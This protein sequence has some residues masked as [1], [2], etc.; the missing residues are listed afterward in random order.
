MPSRDNAEGVRWAKRASTRVEAATPTTRPSPSNTIG[1]SVLMQAR[2][3]WG[4]RTST[5]LDVATEHDLHQPWERLRMLASARRDVRARGERGVEGG[6][7]SSP[8]DAPTPSN[9]YIRSGC[10]NHVYLGRWRREPRCRRAPRGR[11]HRISRTPRSRARSCSRAP[12]GPGRHGVLDEVAVF[13]RAG[14]HLRG[15]YTCTLPR[16]SRVLAGIATTRSRRLAPSRLALEKRHL[17]FAG[18]SRTGSGSGR[19]RHPPT[20]SPALLAAAD[21]CASMPRSVRAR[22]ARRCG[23][24]P[25]RDRRR[26]GAPRG[27]DVFEGSR[28]TTAAHEVASTARPGVRAP[29]PRRRPGETPQSHGRRAGVI[30]LLAEQR[31][32]E[33]PGLVVPGA[34]ST[35]KSRDLRIS[36][37]RRAASGRR[38]LPL[39]ILKDI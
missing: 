5:E 6:G 8:S 17:W 36:T 3:K 23:A 16:G 26:K 12:R 24:C 1:T 27:A 13:R 39:G 35:I 4:A 29:R 28:R 32:A 33:S 22:G 18:S 11:A 37:R 14:G 25:R 20:G 31:N 21:R 9:A 34:R 19:A 15:W 38:A 2:S 30:A 10:G 7:S